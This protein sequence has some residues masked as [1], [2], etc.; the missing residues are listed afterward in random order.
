MKR[1]FPLVVFVLVGAASLSAETTQ[2]IY[3]RGV[4]AYM[5]GNVEEAKIL[6]EQVVAAQPGHRSATAYLKRIDIATPP[7]NALK[8]RVET[9]I[10]PKVDFNDASLSSVLDYLPKVAAQHAPDKGA[11]NIVRMFPMAFGDETKITLHLE[12]VPLSSVLD[13]VASLGGVKLDYQPNAIVVTQVSAV[14]TGGQ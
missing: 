14:P 9:T 10:V 5:G 12:N 6:F 4:R 1:M 11:V 3:A 8:K 2:E 7:E 13:Y